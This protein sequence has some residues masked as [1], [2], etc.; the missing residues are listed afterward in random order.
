VR[1]ADAARLELAPQSPGLLA[2]SLGF[3][4]IYADDRAMLERGITVYDALCLVPRL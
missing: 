3:L 1:G 2:I 4:A